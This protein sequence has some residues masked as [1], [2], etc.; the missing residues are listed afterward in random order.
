MKNTAMLL[1]LLLAVQQ[2]NGQDVITTRDNQKLN[3]KIIEQ[4]AKAVRYRMPDYPDGPLLTLKTIRIAKIEYR[5]GFT[6]MMGYQNP[7]KNRPLGLST[8]YAAGLTGGGSLFSLTADYFIMPQIDLEA[9]F[10]TSDLS[11]DVYYAAGSRIHINSACSV[12]RIT[13]FAGALIGYYYG[14]GIVQLPLGI[15]YISGLGINASVSINRMISFK[16]WE[17][18]FLEIRIGWR[19]KV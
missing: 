11:G 4:T 12:H 7:R 18:T 2:L 9:D 10:G 6:D 1:L 17:S 16:S 19:F 5:N 8:G 14:D 15:S 13:P 3:V